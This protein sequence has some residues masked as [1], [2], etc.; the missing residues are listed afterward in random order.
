MKTKNGIAV[1]VINAATGLKPLDLQ[2]DN[3]ITLVRLPHGQFRVRVHTP[4]LTEVEVNL[5]EVELTKVQVPA[6]VSTIE[7]DSKGAFFAFNPATTD[8]ATPAAAQE[9][10]VDGEPVA[11]GESTSTGDEKPLSADKA[12]GQPTGFL[13]ISVR[14]VEQAPVPGVVP[15]PSN[16]EDV[17]FKLNEPREHARITAANF[18]RIVPAEPLTK[19]WCSC[20]K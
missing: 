5:D 17:L 3:G 2:L 15:P 19:P 16:T 4:H 1:D 18:H 8:N 10:V 11:E 9:V 13:A 14:F 12:L 20:C 7:R 6:G